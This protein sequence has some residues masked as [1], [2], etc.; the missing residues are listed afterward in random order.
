MFARIADL[1]ALPGIS[2]G[3]GLLVV[4]GALILVDFLAWLCFYMGFRAGYRHAALVALSRLRQTVEQ[5]ERGIR[6][7]NSVE[8]CIGY[9]T[10][11]AGHDQR[12]RAA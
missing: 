2:T 9:Q 7:N 8:G 4:F 5:G 6:E 12:E 10:Q 11:E 1:F 3:L